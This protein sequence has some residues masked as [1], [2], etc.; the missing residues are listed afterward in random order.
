MLGSQADV[1]GRKTA[2]NR[3]RVGQYVPAV[4]SVGMPV[5]VCLHSICSHVNEVGGF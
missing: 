5:F 1:V 3:V 2:R 4:T